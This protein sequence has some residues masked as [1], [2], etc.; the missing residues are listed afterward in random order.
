MTPKREAPP[1]YST[2]AVRVLRLPGGE[3]VDDRVAVEEPLELRIGG[4]P[5]AVT[6][7]TPG[8]DEELALGFALSEG[9]PAALGPRARRPRGEHDRA[10][11]ARLRP[12]ADRA[13]VLHDVVLR[14]LREG[15]A[16]GDRRRVAAGRERAHDQR[17]ARRARCPIASARRR[18]R[19]PRPAGSTR[20]GSSPP[21]ASS[22]ARERTSAGTT[23]WTR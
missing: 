20:R 23:R 7:R 11:G 5:V 2:A 16:R 15:G 3:E 18:R 4:R 6:M 13:L 10:R 17:R 12:R 22:C 8:H 19:S 9:P 21:P 1:A 14:R